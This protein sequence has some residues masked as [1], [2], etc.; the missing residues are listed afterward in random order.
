VEAINHPW[1]QTFLAFGEGV[2]RLR[3]GD[4]PKA[5][6]TLEKS[7]ALC[8]QWQL[9]ALFEVI[10]G[11]LG[12]AY[13]LAGRAAEAIPLLE[14]ALERGQRHWLEP[15]PS[16]ALA[17]AYL[18]ADRAQD[19]GQQAERAFVLARQRGQR[20]HEAWLR[21]L[22][23]EIAAHDAAPV[24]P[25][26]EEHYREALSLAT[27]LRMRPLI[28]HCHRGLGD[29]YRRSGDR[30]RA[31]EHLTT[32]RMLYREMNVKLWLSEMEAEPTVRG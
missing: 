7:L 16:L 14:E 3:Q 18:R 20:G 22:L 12:A 4:L 26:A 30:G 25:V 32:A 19:A 9:M 10:A 5:I 23:G 17:E 15:V 29:W 24:S 2:L 31:E 27:E 8:R 6:T 13:T 21:W 1:S 28:A 11:H